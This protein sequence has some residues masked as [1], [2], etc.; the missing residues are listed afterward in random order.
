MSKLIVVSNRVNF[1]NPKGQSA[2]GLGVALQDAL[3]EVGGIW[4]G[5][6]GE[7]IENHEVQYFHHQEFSPI[8]YI[9]CPLTEQQYQD[10]YCG[11]ANKSL[12]PA[13]HD[14]EDL[15]EYHPQAYQTYQQVNQMFAHQLNLV[16]EEN[17]MI[18]IHDY[19]FMSVAHYC[20]ELGMRN[21]FGFFLH[22]PFAGTEIWSQ[23]PVAEQL[24]THLSQYDVLGLQTDN[25]QKNCTEVLHYYVG[26]HIMDDVLITSE[27]QV[28]IQAYPIGVN[29][30]L[31]QKT[32]EVA[33]REID[34]SIFE[35]DALVNQKTIIAVDRIDYSKGLIERFNAFAEFLK[36]HPEY[37]QAV[38]DLQIACPCRMDIPAYETLF[39]DVQQ[40][41]Q[42]INAQF[43]QDQW[44]PINCTH[45]TVAHDQLMN[46]YRKS[47]ICWVNS[48]K[49]G[50]NLVA[51]EFVAAQDPDDPGVL[52]LSKY[53]GSADQMSEALIVDPSYKQSMVSALSLALKMSRAERIER[54]K[55]LMK[56]LKSFDIHAWSNAFL[57]DLKHFNHIRTVYPRYKTPKLDSH[58]RGLSH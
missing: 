33:E 25:D 54:Y 42:A 44:A 34:Q 13:M 26:G 41:V 17:D 22:I 2:G 55:S 1:P 37:H 45:Q 52:I 11:F 57:K 16:A 18:W 5:W 35:F 15:I 10:Y 38:T 36:L 23:I 24:I 7:Q 20:R 31:I 30:D 46:I 4:L 47:D 58:Y 3:N 50:M 12:W 53:A 8:E 32:A 9:T 28:K 6:N 27:R 40:K 43:A 48:L 29:P 14:R 21:R 49:D 19:H 56:G 39:K 51:K